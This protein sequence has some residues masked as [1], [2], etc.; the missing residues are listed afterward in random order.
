MWPITVYIILALTVIMNVVAIVKTFNVGTFTEKEES[1]VAPHF[2]KPLKPLIVEEK[3]SAVLE[4]AVVGKP[5]PNIKWFKDDKEIKPDKTRR[6]SYNPETG[7]ATLELLEPT[8]N[9]ETVYRVTADNKFGKAQ[10]RANLIISKAVEVTQPVV[11][12][13][14]KITKPIKAVVAQPNTDIVLEAEFEGTPK[15]TVT[16]LKNSKPIKPSKD[17]EIV[18]EDTKTTLK[19]SK[20][21]PQKGGKYEIRAVNPRGEATSSGSVTITEDKETMQATPPKFIQPIKPQTVAPGEVVIMEAVVEAFPTASFTWFQRSTPIKSSPET[22]ITTSENKS[23]LYIREVKHDFVGPITCRAE[24]VAGS[25]TCTASL[26]VVE[27]TEWEETTELEY[28]R[29]VKQMSPVRV[30]DG[31]KIT[32]T[33]K[34]AGKPLPKTEW[35]HNGQPVKEAKDVTISQDSEGV[36]MLSISEVFPENAGE[37]ICQAVNKVGEAVCKSSLIVEGKWEKLLKLFGA[38]SLCCFSL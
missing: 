28:P 25:V 37:Y 27:E 34:V 2:V 14:P 26:N 20:G 32:F 15:P 13:A 3:K 19:I 11:T 9:D 8:P 35:F 6:L 4:C 1:G 38:L 10:C 36:C 7:V 33:C 29:F 23:V 5:V 31:E 18:T 21:V 24:N 17:F 22:R 12:T 16:W 30:M